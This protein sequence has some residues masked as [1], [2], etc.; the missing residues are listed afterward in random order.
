ME[1]V[2]Y[3]D[4]L[5]IYAQVYGALSRAGWRVYWKEGQGLA[6]AGLDQVEKG[7]VLIWTTPWG[8]RAYDLKGTVFLT[9]RDDPKTLALGLTIRAMTGNE[10]Q[11]GLRL[12]P[13]ER[14]VL[15]AAG[16][17]VPL[18]AGPMA[19]ALG[20]PRDRVRFFLKGAVNKFGLGEEDLVRL[21]RHQ[22]QVMGFKDYL[23]PLPGA[24]VQPGLDVPG[25]QYLEADGSLEHTPVGEAFRVEVYQHAL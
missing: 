10:G 17:G 18:K 11:V 21:A 6:L 15:L 2:V 7:E 1:A 9:R 5:Y 13:G 14:L 20:L 8:L 19:R 4:S 22:V 16:R 12:L 3:T 24:Q 23:E 25:E